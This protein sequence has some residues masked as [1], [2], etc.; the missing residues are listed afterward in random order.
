[1]NEPA[2]LVCDSGSTKAD[3]VVL[4][5]RGTQS[6]RTRGLQP[7]FLTAEEIAAELRA[8]LLPITRGFA[9]QTVYFYGSGCSDDR[10]R[11]IVERG[12]RLVLPQ[13]RLHVA[14]THDLLG[15][16]RATCGETAGLVGI[17]GTGSN[18]CHFDGA[19]IVDNVPS[20]GYLLGDEGSGTY[21]GRLLVRAYF[22]RELSAKT[23]A[24][25]ER[26]LPGGRSAL[27]ENMY[28]RPRPNAFLARFT[29]PLAELRHV[30][31]VQTLIYR[32]LDDFV[33]RHLLK[34]RHA[35]ALPVHFVGSIAAVFEPELRTVLARHGR[36]F[37]TVLHRPVEGLVEYHTRALDF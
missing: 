33:T 18:S 27:L 37:G 22:Y 6:V 16:A 17:L 3:W 30:P 8:E 4:H 2:V 15:A 1:M 11:G 14:I 31:E 34:Y 24:H 5:R 28:H 12:V 21:L 32:G 7:F 29:Y 23:A 10:T 20:L 25:V 13:P 36:P 19:R 9:V 35:S 26:Y